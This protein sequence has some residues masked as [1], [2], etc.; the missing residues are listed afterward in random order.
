MTIVADVEAPSILLVTDG[1]S[2]AWR[3]TGLEGGSQNRYAVVPANYALRA[4]PLGAGHHRLRL[5]Y[6]PTAFVV[7]A[8]ISALATIAYAGVLARWRAQAGRATRHLVANG[9]A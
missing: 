1:Y 2:R 3:A 6:R 9:T 5:E 8:W 7:G 4:V